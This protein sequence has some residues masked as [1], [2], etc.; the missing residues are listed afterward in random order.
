VNALR[1]PRRWWGRAAA[2]AVL[3][4]PALLILRVT[5]DG[6]G[7]RAGAIMAAVSVLTAAAVLAP[8]AFRPPVLTAGGARFRPLRF[9]LR[10]IT[11]PWAD[12]AHADLL[13]VNSRIHLTLVP[14]DPGRYVTGG[15]L[16]RILMRLR[17]DSGRGFHLFVG[18][19]PYRGVA[20]REAVERFSGGAV[21]IVEPP[22]PAEPPVDPARLAVPRRAFRPSPRSY[23]VI[24]ALCVVGIALLWAGSAGDWSVLTCAGLLSLAVGAAAV[25]VQSRRTELSGDGFRTRA[26]RMPWHL[27]TAVEETRLGPARWLRLLLW[28]GRRALLPGPVSL[29]GAD[30]RFTADVAAIREACP[31][32]VNRARPKQTTV[33]LVV[34]VLLGV[35]LYQDRPWH[36]AF[37]PGVRIATATP[38]ACAAAAD[39]ARR[40]VPGT[41]PGRPGNPDLGTVRTCRFADERGHEWLLI[42]AERFS[43]DDGDD[44]PTRATKEY[45][46]SQYIWTNGGQEAPGIADA[47]RLKLNG[48]T[49]GLVTGT[50]IAR[51]ANVVFHIRYTRTTGTEE[52]AS[53]ALKEVTRAVA[54]AVSLH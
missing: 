43:P 53:T 28:N 49:T 15:P 23:P 51:R 1:L 13:P 40:L 33:V 35:A 36:R 14:K 12:V 48:S 50:M 38:D 29:T 41:T 46:R 21:R 11:M 39:T 22:L 10:S 19:D 31:V 18:L 24:A 27:V 25:V 8:L 54:T 32:P 42:E 45:D 6:Y 4:L 52:D 17:L 44:A 7:S 9:G 34:L 37:W 47:A 5:V 30:P 16:R 20:V 26:G 2:A 3:I